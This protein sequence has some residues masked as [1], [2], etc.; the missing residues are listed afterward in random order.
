MQPDDITPQ[1]R[2][3]RI[4]KLIM[5]NL[6]RLVLLVL[7]IMIIGLSMAVKKKNSQL[8]AEKA[9]ALS[10]ERPSVNAV[11][12]EV[13]PGAIHDRINLPGEIAPWTRL[14]MMAKIRGAVEEILVIEGQQVKEGE[15]LARIEE[16]DYRIALDAAK[17]NY[18]LAKV[19][20]ERI[21]RLHE[22]DIIPTAELDKSENQ[23]RTARAAM[24]DAAL[25]LSRCSI[26]APMSGVI[27]RLDLKKGLMLSVGDPMAELLKIDQVKAVIGIPESDVAAVRGLDTV[28]FTIQALDDRRI[29]GR[30]FFLSSSPENQARLYRL[31]LAVDNPRREILPGMFLRANIIKKTVGQAIIVPLY[32]V[33]TR[34]DEHYVFVEKDGVAEKRLVTLGIMEEWQAQVTQGLAAGERVIIEGHRDVEAGQQV[35]TIKLLTDVG[36]LR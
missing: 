20:I 34:N 13:S 16:A 29:T 17:A 35:N 27:R 4:V 28:E 23:M 14:E 25:N 26:T 31:E 9:A 33:L 5:Q 19:N 11:L 32:A 30:K 1:T 15:V 22:Q 6:P 2:R 18:D 12:L 21:K 10:K 24:D 8:T 7:V 36:A 3:G